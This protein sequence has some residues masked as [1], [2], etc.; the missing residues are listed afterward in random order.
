MYRDN[1]FGPLFIRSFR[2]LVVLCYCASGCLKQRFFGFKNLHDYRYDVRAL[3][4]RGFR[5]RVIDVGKN[6]SKEPTLDQ[7]TI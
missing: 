4:N 6:Q 1:L 5:N 7:K 3:T 2:V